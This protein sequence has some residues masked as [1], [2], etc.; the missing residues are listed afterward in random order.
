METNHNH[1]AEIYLDSSIVNR[2]ETG[3]EGREVVM[4]FIK[5][6]NN[7]DFKTARS[8]V[9]DDMSFEGVLGSRAGAEAYFKDMERMKIK[10]NIRKVFIDGGDVC[11]LYDF[12]ISKVSVFGCGLYHVDNGKINSLRVVFDPRPII[13]SPK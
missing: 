9:R 3:K 7:E 2:N 12:T 11:L 6:L 4:S 13:G 1:T 10:Y 5:A 8:F